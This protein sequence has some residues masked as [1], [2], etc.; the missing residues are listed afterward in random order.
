MECNALKNYLEQIQIQALTYND[1]QQSNIL[2][3]FVFDVRNRIFAIDLVFKKCKN[4]K[5]DQVTI[6]NLNS[7]KDKFILLEQTKLS[8]LSNLLACKIIEVDE[9]KKSGISRLFAIFFPIEKVLQ[10]MFLNLLDVL[11]EFQLK[12]DVFAF[13]KRCNP[14]IIVASIYTKLNRLKYLEQINVCFVVIQKCINSILFDKIIE[15]YPFPKHY[16]KLL[17]RWLKSYVINETKTYKNLNQNKYVI[18]E[19]FVLIR[20]IV[21]FLL[22]NVFYK[23]IFKSIGKKRR[24]IWVEIYSYADDILVISNNAKLFFKQLCLLK[25]KLNCIGLFLNNDK[26]QLF[27]NVNKK[28]KFIFLGFEFVVIPR[29]K[30]KKNLLFSKKSFNKHTI[31]LQLQFSVIKKVKKMLKN[32]MKKIY[33]LSCKKVYKLFY[34]VNSILFN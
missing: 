28:I 7:K 2:M 4:F 10:Q 16:K 11:I 26:T 3:P 23:R 30:L 29:N 5:Y 15:Q 19:D 8:N 31:I 22:S 18:A 12:S 1:N 32:D 21:S 17:I 34:S 24:Y 27:V 13:R 6:S 20:S 14:K 9:V 25:K 33:H